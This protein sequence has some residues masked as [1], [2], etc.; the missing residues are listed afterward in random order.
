[1][2][3]RTKFNIHGDNIV[4]CER[5]M[6]LIIR[7]FADEIKSI[8]GPSLSPVCPCYTI[9]FNDDSNIEFQFIPGF[10]RWNFNVMDGVKQRGG[11]LRE[12]ADVILTE[13]NDEEKKETPLLAIEFCG[14][15]PAGNQAWQRSGR[16]YSFGC[17][18]IPY[19]YVAELSGYELD[20]NRA[21]KAARMPNQAVPFSYV[22]FSIKNETPVL[23]VFLANPGADDTFKKEYANIFSDDDLL[24]FVKAIITKQNYC[25]ISESLKLKILSFVEKRSS[26]KSNNASLSS[27]EW[28]ELYRALESGSELV[29]YLSEKTNLPWKKTAYIASLTNETKYLFKEVSNIAKGLTSKNLPMCII[30]KDKRNDFA[31]IVNK[32]GEN[33]ISTDLKNWLLNEKHLVVC[34]V[35]GFKPKGDDARPDRGLTPLVRMLIGQNADLLTIVYGPAPSS[36]WDRL[37]NS[38][39]ELSNTNG[40]WQSILGTSDA[41]IGSSETINQKIVGYHSNHWKDNKITSISN[42]ID[43]ALF[44]KVVA[45]PTRFGEN[46]VDTVTHSLLS[47]GGKDFVF[48]GMCN[49]PGGDWSGLSLQNINRTKEYRFLS[50]PRVSDKNEKRPD[51]V[52]QIFIGSKPIILVIESKE[53]AKSVEN[54]IGP[55]LVGYLETL[56]N[57]KP[58]IERNPNTNEWVHSEDYVK[59]SDFRMASAIAFIEK[60][61]SSIQNTLDR[62]SSDIALA[63]SF[64]KDASSCSLIVIYKTALGKEIASS[65][66]NINILGVNMSDVLPSS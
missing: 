37:E 16:S 32:L 41:I 6:D 58:S 64:E 24:F 20:K 52:F 42:K 61:I 19:L 13:V 35:M 12:A 62:S 23:P 21:R 7:S 66:S 65:I 56:S 26:T 3:S 38:P 63:F 43:A 51:H 36:H 50:L 10:G 39:N 48:E 47:V 34:W 57:N 4:E 18:K 49:P 8:S 33:K 46:D 40:L 54:E 27:S 30:T 53:T 5:M 22:T 45:C 28:S 15:L 17:S 44:D 11:I 1:M 60:D 25:S 29:D 59:L 55:R 31:Q 9:N 14:A 2:I